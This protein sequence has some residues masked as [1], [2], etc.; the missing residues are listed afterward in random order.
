MALDGAG[1]VSQV[2]QLDVDAAGF[3]AEKMTK[4]SGVLRSSRIDL[5]YEPFT[6]FPLLLGFCSFALHPSRLHREQCNPFFEKSL[7]MCKL[8][9]TELYTITAVDL[10]C[11][12]RNPLSCAPAALTQ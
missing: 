2:V 7:W 11:Q 3:L 9:G 8:P 5:G 1:H 6:K 4:F 10:V 12:N